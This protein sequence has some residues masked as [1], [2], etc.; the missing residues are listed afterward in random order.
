LHA[1]V[2]NP[3]TLAQFTV[4]RVP[5]Q[6]S[7]QPLL[8]KLFIT[9]CNETLNGARYTLCFKATSQTTLYDNSKELM[10]G[11]VYYKGGEIAFFGS[12]TVIAP[13][14][15]HPISHG[16]LVECYINNS[17]TILGVMPQDFR[18]KL[19][20]AIQASITLTLER[21]QHWITRL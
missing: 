10:A 2:F 4:L 16:H 17:L 20:A 15:P 5:Y 3:E 14:N 1:N 6:Y 12:N 19:L 8:S 18:G 21:K 13:D 7:G 11:C 9:L